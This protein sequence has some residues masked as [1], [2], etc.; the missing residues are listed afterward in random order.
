MKKNIGT[1][2]K[3][4]R[5][6]IAFIFV[7]LYFTEIVTG[8]IGIVLLTLGVVFV[9]TSLVSFCPIYTILGINT[10]PSKSVKN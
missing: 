1:T 3:L 10:C 6:L 2:D 9:L 8:T 5:I 7:A 4:I